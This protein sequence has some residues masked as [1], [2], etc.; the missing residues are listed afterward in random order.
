METTGHKFLQQTTQQVRRSIIDIDDSYNN[1]WDI[2]A[3]LTQ[4]AVDAI[5]KSE[6]IDGEINIIIDALNKSI[7][8]S[9]NGIGID[10]NK[11]PFLIAPFSTDKD[12]DENTIGEKGVGLTFVLFSCNDFYIK[13][14][15]TTGT[16][17][18]K[19]LDA[20]NWKYSSKND[21]IEFYQSDLTENYIG[22]EVTLKNIPNSPLFNFSTKQLIFLCRTR[23][24]IGSTNNI[25]HPDINIKVNLSHTNQDG[26]ITKAVIP[27]KFWLA[28][29]GLNEDSLIDI[30]D[31]I[32]YSSDSNRSD[33]DKRIKLKDK[34]IYNNHSFE[35]SGRT[36]KAYSCYVPKRK[37]WD[38]ISI[39]ND[40]CTKENIENLEWLDQY[41]YLFFQQGITTSVKGMPTGISIDHPVTG[42]AGSWANLFILF[43]DR[44][45]KF[46]IGRKS[47]HGM[48]AKILKNYSKEIFNEYRK[49]SKYISGDIDFENQ[50]EKDEIFSQLNSYVNLGLNN[51][52]HLKVPKYQEATIASL[53]FECIG[54][55]TI[56]DISPLISG[57]KN[58][59]DLYAKWNNRN[60]VIEFKTS[61]KNILKDFNDEIKIFHEI[62]CIVCWEITLDDTQAFN[63]RGITLERLPN[64]NLPG[65]NQTYFPNATH[66]LVIASGFTPPV[67]VID[68]KE[69]LGVQ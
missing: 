27:F 26:I 22:T 20:Y 19:V 45:I 30:N 53:F 4:N 41:P 52:K 47:I 66:R 50:W 16:S 65:T 33:Q 18:G 23:T 37:T 36:I 63:D 9:D 12:V 24:A 17:E 67:Y 61:V 69:L 2:L 64:G 15:T 39:K 25:W 28:T 40:I 1:D 51:F 44:Q 56:S 11:L 62:N 35:H 31:F 8:V 5:R 59:Y 48:Q 21:D 7:T 68:L 42:Q 46:D 32:V 3:E 34:I 43:E 55:G 14:G 29:E 58:K 6:R 10:K 54:N 49:I 38:E 60:V 13:S 57:H